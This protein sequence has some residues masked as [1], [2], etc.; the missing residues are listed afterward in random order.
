MTAIENACRSEVTVVYVLRH[1]R[2][3]RAFLT[4][5][6]ELRAVTTSLMSAIGADPGGYGLAERPDR[7]GWFVEVI[8]FATE[9]ER[10]RFDDLYCRDRRASAVQ[11]LLDDLVDAKRSD[12]VLTRREPQ[13]C[14]PVLTRS[15][16]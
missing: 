16:A 14:A 5:M 13:R 2:Y 7:D 9:K 3:R 12:Y 10:H 11:G 1:V 6:S 15:C 8:R 4:L